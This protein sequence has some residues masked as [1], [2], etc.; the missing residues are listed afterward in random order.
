MEE[1]EESDDNLGDSS[2]RV[3][4]L[5]NYVKDD[6]QSSDDIEKYFHE[7]EDIDEETE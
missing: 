5:E 7:N 3:Q 4:F 2:K 1:D 6:E